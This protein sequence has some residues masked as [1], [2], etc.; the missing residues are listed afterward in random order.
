MAWEMRH[1]LTIKKAAPIPCGAGE[2]AVH[3]GGQ[4]DD[5]HELAKIILGGNDA[6]QTRDTPGPPLLVNLEGEGQ[7]PVYSTFINPRREGPAAGGEPI[8]VT[9][10]YIAELRAPQAAARRQHGNGFHQVGFSRTVRPVKTYMTAIQAQ[11][12]LRVV[13]EILQ[14]D[15]PEA[16]G[17]TMRL[18]QTVDHSRASSLLMEDMRS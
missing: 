5:P 10:E 11:M 6:I 7:A 15:P 16:N 13:A 3:R 17:R 18:G 2:D 14:P 12:E 1:H 4:P 8:A 9:P